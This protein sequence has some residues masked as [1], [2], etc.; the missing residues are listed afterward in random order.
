MREVVE[1]EEAEEVTRTP[2][3]DEAEFG[4]LDLDGA[5]FSILHAISVTTDRRLT[6]L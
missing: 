3:L 4:A 2:S 6:M 1:D 5:E